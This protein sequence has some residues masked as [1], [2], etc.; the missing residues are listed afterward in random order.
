MILI[1]GF[2]LPESKSKALVVSQF[3]GIFI[4]DNSKYSNEGQFLN[5]V[6]TLV[7]A[8]EVTYPNLTLVRS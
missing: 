1:A 4:D 7:K 3:A 8:V 5:I 2:S 6:F